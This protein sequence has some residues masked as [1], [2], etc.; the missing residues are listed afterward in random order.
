MVDAFSNN[1]GKGYFFRTAKLSQRS[2]VLRT[3]ICRNLV[4]FCGKAGWEGRR[5]SGYQPQQKSALRIVQNEFRALFKYLKISL[6][7]AGKFYYEIKIF[8]S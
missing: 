8:I 5:L 6:C 3:S 1:G 2:R 7:E 4:S